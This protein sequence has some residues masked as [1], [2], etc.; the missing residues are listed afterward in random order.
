MF[1][2]LWA[3]HPQISYSKHILKEDISSIDG[4]PFSD[5]GTTSSTGHVQYWNM[6]QYKNMLQYRNTL[7]YWNTWNLQNHPPSVW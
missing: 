2:P 6:F 7:Q 4:T 5:T 3:K 1:Q